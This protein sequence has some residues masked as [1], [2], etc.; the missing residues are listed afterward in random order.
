LME[1]GEVVTDLAGCRVVVYSVP[2]EERVTELV[3]RAF[4]LPD[5]GDARPPPIRRPSGYQ[6]THTLVLAPEA[7]DDTSIRGSIC[8]VQVATVAA[9][10]F[11]ELEHDIAYKKLGHDATAP[12]TRLLASVERACKLADH[13]VEQLLDERARGR[14]R[15]VSLS[16]PAELRLALEQ[17]VGHPLTGDFARLF[18][19]LD[20]VVDPLTA[21]ALEQLG[22]PNE[23]LARGQA[24][25]TKLGLQADD[26]TAYVLGILPEY[27]AEFA[28]IAAHWRGPKTA[29]RRAIQSGVRRGA[30]IEQT[31]GSNDDDVDG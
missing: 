8:E 15:L 25:A 28:L 16:D 22:K 27:K 12:E 23:L 21:A 3:R 2:D 20:T 11:N 31:T 19:M 5:R 7:Q 30:K 13:V 6:A 14:A 9:H 18:K 4:A 29:L 26:V 17:A 1:I 24:E 10:L